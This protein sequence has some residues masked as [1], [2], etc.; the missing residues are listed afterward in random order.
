MPDHSITIQRVTEWEIRRLFNEDRYY[1]RGQS[2]EFRVVVKK[3]RPSTIVSEHIPP[4]S[5]SQDVRYYDQDNNEV[6]RVSCFRRPDGTCTL[7]D[8]KR[9][10]IGDIIYRIIP[11]G[12]PTP[13][14]KGYESPNDSPPE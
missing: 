4:G 1:E 13:R 5:I 3:E 12:V 9:L 10:R 11:G 6:A 2:G 7:H 8:P 14:P